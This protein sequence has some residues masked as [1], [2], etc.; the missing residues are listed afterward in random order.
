[1][2]K[3]VGVAKSGKP[4]PVGVEEFLGRRGGWVQVVSGV[5]VVCQ[6]RGGWFCD[7]LFWVVLARLALEVMGVLGR[8][9]VG[10]GAVGGK[11]GGSA[12]FWGADGWYG[13]T[14]VW[15]GTKC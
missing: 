9:W 11:R 4:Y 8:L 6:E 10:G 3:Q 13:G 5:E 12:V 14:S 15:E 2:V 1:M 7:G